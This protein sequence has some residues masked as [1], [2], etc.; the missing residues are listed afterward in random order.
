MIPMI[1]IAVMGLVL[2]G[3]SLPAA[4]QGPSAVADPSSRSASGEEQPPAELVVNGKL[5]G[6]QVD[7][8]PT[9]ICLVCNQPLQEGDVVYRV[10]GQRVPVHLDSCDESFR[11][12][13]ANWLARLKPHGAF[14]GAPG[15]AQALSNLWFF[16]G[17]YVLLGL[18][19]AALCAHQALHLGYSPVLWFAV[20]LLINAFGYLFLLTRPKRQVQAPAGIPGGLGKV[21]ATY[22][23]RLCA[24]CGAANHPSA[25]QC[26]A[27]CAKLQPRMPS[28]V[29][30]AGLRPH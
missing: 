21:A 30:K 1:R 27:C 9:E 6:S 3:G 28:E 25:I 22:E 13:L 12:N 10:Q 15:D 5:I 20:G 14:L 18:L 24:S 23:P 8:R 16:I 7:P 19:F 4:E 17:F 26:I 11:S 2:Q 29:E